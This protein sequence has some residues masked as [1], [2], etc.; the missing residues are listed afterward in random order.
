MAEKILKRNGLDGFIKSM[1]ESYKVFGPMAE[2][3]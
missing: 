2:G 1:G 3:R